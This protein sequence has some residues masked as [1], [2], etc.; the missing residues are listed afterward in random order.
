[1]TKKCQS[2]IINPMR[3]SFYWLQKSTDKT[4]T[5][6]QIIISNDYKIRFAKK[7]H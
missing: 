7:N 4:Q 1:M 6:R 5:L 3:Q 2:N